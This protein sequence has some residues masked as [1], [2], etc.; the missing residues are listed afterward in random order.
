MKKGIFL[1]VLREESDLEDTSS[2]SCS[3][4]SSTVRRWRFYFNHIADSA[5]IVIIDGT[6]DRSHVFKSIVIGVPGPFIRFPS[7]SFLTP[8]GPAAW[9]LM[10]DCRCVDYNSR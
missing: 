2:S 1:I 4:A 6:N 9:I 5:L 10:L 8:I 7:H 3:S